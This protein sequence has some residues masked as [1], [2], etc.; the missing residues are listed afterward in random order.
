MTATPGIMNS[1]TM[2]A[3]VQ[4]VYSLKLLATPTPSYVYRFPAMTKIMPARSGRVFRM[5]RYNPLP[6][7]P[8]QITDSGAEPPNTVGTTVDVDAEVKYFAQT[9][10]ISQIV[11]LTSQDEVL[12]GWSIRMAVSLR[13]TEDTVI[14]N[15]LVA[16]AS[17]IDAQG[18]A[19]Q[20][21]PTQHGKIDFDTLTSLFL[22]ANGLS[23]AERIGAEDEFG[24]SPQR[25]SYLMIAHSSIVRDLERTDG[26][27]HR[28]QYPGGGGSVLPSEWGSVG[29]QR[30]LLSTNASVSP[31]SSQAGR[32]VLNCIATASEGY[33]IV[34]QSG[35]SSHFIYVPPEI[36]SP[37]TRLYSSI[38]WRMATATSISSQ[39]WVLNSRCTLSDF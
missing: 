24:T 29:S 36:A 28:S 31:K 38:G 12:N 21:S 19:N 2:P 16:T 14:R 1:Q 22:E 30:I 10:A 25:N 37:R 35:F 11:T 6:T 8:V 5:R 34:K 20:D 33:Y 32:D 15:A 23:L 26:F 27:V 3:P 13:G 9:M 18:G 4:L 17:R 7:T 39:D